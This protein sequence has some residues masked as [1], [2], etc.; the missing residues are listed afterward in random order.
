MYRVRHGRRY[1]ACTP[2]KRRETASE[3]FE[4]TVHVYSA[5]VNMYNAHVNMYNVHACTCTCVYSVYM[6]TC[7]LSLSSQRVANSSRVTPV[8]ALTVT[9]DPH[10]ASEA[11]AWR[12]YESRTNC[13]GRQ[14]RGHLTLQLSRG[15]EEIKV[16]LY[17][18]I[19]GL[20]TYSIHACTHTYIVHIHVH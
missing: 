13:E 9:F 8:S 6:Y 15:D 10:M 20:H 5:H 19:I 14:R 16:L 3:A 4:Y 2:Q 1:S 17:N 18:S 12:D 11:S 7:K